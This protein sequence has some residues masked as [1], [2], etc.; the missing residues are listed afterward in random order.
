MS[1]KTFLDGAIGLGEE[2]FFDAEKR[3]IADMLGSAMKTV[4]QND[5]M[6]CIDTTMLIR[7]AMKAAGI[8][9]EWLK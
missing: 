9:E 1:E 7:D 8:P 6:A 4:L 3:R 5:P 2:G